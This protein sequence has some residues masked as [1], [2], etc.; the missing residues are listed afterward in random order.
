MAVGL[1]FGGFV[2]V[3]CSFLPRLYIL[4]QPFGKSGS[5]FKEKMTSWAGKL[6]ITHSRGSLSRSLLDSGSSIQ[7]TALD[8]TGLSEQWPLPAAAAAAV[9]LDT[10]SHLH[11]DGRQPGSNS[12]SSSSSSGSAE[13]HLT[14]AERAQ[15]SQGEQ[16]QVWSTHVSDVVQQMQEFAQGLQ[17]TRQLL[18]APAATSQAHTLAPP[19]GAPTTPQRQQQPLSRATAA[20]AGAAQ[21]HTLAA[22]Q[23]AAQKVAAAQSGAKAAQEAAQA[24]GYPTLYVVNSHI[25]DAD[26]PRFYKAGDAFVLPSR[27]EGWGRPHV[28]AMA[29]GLPVISTNWSGITAYLD[30]SVGY[31]IAVDGL[32]P[33]SVS[34][35][36]IMWW[37]RGLNWAQPSVKHLAQL[38]RRVYSNRAEAAARGAA[39][40]ARMVK[41]YSPEAIA[42]VVVKELQ[43][44]QGKLP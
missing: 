4:T 38:M 2:P 9:G 8:L 39:G 28:E 17:H 44:I 14:G 35:D 6:N 25:A 27:G 3:C 10:I 1:S 5:S 7:H 18:A 43:R 21:P 36:D 41:L 26:F 42:D 33:V 24:G 12:G 19:P 40:R 22:A 34:G 15:N 30:E 23:A 29:M 32:V 31:P 20:A 11:S 37:F 13:G 16:Q